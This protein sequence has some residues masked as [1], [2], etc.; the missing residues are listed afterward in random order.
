M[1]EF[2]GCGLSATSQDILWSS[3]TLPEVDPPMWH[4]AFN[5]LLADA[6]RVSNA[7]RLNAQ[8]FVLYLRTEWR[9]KVH[10]IYG[11]E[12]LAKKDQVEHNFNETFKSAFKENH[13][14]IYKLVGKHNYGHHFGGFYN[15]IRS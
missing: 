11:T 15:R 3:C 10:M 7:E 2:I 6:D 5:I 1:R 12:R 14:S 4:V 9:D 8:R 13:V